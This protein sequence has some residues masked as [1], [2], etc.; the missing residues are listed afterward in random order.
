MFLQG[1]STAPFFMDIFFNRFWTMAVFMIMTS[2][3]LFMI[4]L[5][6]VIV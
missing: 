6:I 3:A 5:M 4:M 2:F 1:A